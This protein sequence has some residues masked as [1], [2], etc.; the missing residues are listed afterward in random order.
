MIRSAYK[1]KIGNMSKLVEEKLLLHLDLCRE[2]YNAALQE[3]RD[4]WKLNKINVTYQDQQ[5]VLPEIKAVRPEYI[6]IHSQVLQDVLKRLDKSFQNFFR[7]VK[8]GDK[9]GFPRFK[10][11]NF[12]DSFCFPQ[13]GWKLDGN[14]LTLSKIGQVKLRLHRNI[15]GKVK[16]CSIK[17]EDTGWFVIF[18]VEQERELLPETNQVIGVDAG[19]TNLL[20]LSDGTV[21]DNP[22]FIESSQRELRILQRNVARKKKGGKNR[23]KAVL[24]LRKLHRKITNCRKDFFHKLA[25]GLIKK[26][27]FLAIEDLRV[28]NMLRNHNLARVIADASWSNF[29]QM[30]LNKAEKAGRKLVKVPAR[31][32]SQTCFSC[33]FCHSDNRLSQAK[34]EC[35]SCNYFEN[36][37]LNAARNILRAG[38]A[39]L[40]KTWMVTSSVSK[41]APQL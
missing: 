9:P 24:K 6:G 10:G 7:R 2:L 11:K 34:F 26:Y 39:L 40:D 15:A 8:S 37:D 35:Q 3:R 5:N 31:H 28:S 23:R 38:L 18:S 17:R 14:K 12:F 16:T 13:T 41:E 1:F 4:A 25:N 27:D 21:I 22:R 20:T 30:L 32:T 36:A 33:G 19:I 29:Y